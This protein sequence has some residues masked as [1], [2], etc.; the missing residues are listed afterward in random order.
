MPNSMI[1]GIYFLS[2]LNCFNRHKLDEQFIIYSV[3][4]LT[5][6]RRLIV[7]DE[8][9]SLCVCLIA[10]MLLAKLLTLGS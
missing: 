3:P 6:G 2:I 9:L 1:I 7:G 10:T 5:I 4:P 8:F